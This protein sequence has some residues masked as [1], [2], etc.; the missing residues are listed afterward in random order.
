MNYP[1][2]DTLKKSI[3]NKWNK[4]KKVINFREQYPYCKRREVWWCSLGQNVGSEQSFSDDSF[5]RP[6]LVY[7]VF[8][9]DTFLG[10]P[11]T[12]KEHI[13]ISR[14][15]KIETPPIGGVSRVFIYT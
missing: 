2:N 8:S 10:L 11:I 4:L 7:K 5:A 1:N 12:S 9:R 3:F 15:I 6:V 14:Y 13:Q